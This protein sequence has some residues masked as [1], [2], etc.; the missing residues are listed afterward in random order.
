MMVI[1]KHVLCKNFR[2]KSHENGKKSII[3]VLIQAFIMH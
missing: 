2:Q 1:E 3:I